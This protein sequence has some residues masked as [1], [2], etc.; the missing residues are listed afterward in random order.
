MC[1][2]HQ[3]QWFTGIEKIMKVGMAIIQCY[4]DNQCR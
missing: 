3:L 4:E 1:K 2:G